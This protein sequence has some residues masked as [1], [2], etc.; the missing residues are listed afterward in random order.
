MKTE[1]ARKEESGV[2]EEEESWRDRWTRRKADESTRRTDDQIAGGWTEGPC[3]QLLRGSPPPPLP[4]EVTGME[5]KYFPT[6]TF[7]ESLE[8]KKPKGRIKASVLRCNIST[9]NSPELMCGEEGSEC[10]KL[11]MP[12]A[13]LWGLD[14]H[15]STSGSQAEHL[16]TPPLLPG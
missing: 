9:A 3:V 10:G 11:A 14:I 1:R 2:G 5:Q 16:G 6:L 8:L 12:R 13:A 7:Q 4:E 15:I